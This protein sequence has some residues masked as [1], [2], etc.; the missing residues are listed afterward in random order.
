MAEEFSAQTDETLMGLY[1][2]G[3]EQAFNLL[4]ARYSA[5][6]YGYLRQRLQD[7]QAANDVFQLTFTKLHRSRVQYNSS[8]PFAPWLFTIVRN[9]L[10]DWMKSKKTNEKLREDF[11]LSERIFNQPIFENL[12]A[13][14]PVNLSSLPMNQRSA[15]EMRYFEELPFE[16]IA[17]RLETSPANVRQLISR[18]IRQLKNAL[19]GSGG[20]Q[21]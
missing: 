20:G 4:Y 19:P 16:E 10:L 11:E 12:N 18:G 1:M 15:I 21:R 9:A 14:D 7:P 8:F 3:N 6:V 5:R 17:K 13:A 2:N